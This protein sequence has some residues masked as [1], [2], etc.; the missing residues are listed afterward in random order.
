[1]TATNPARTASQF[2]RDAKG[3]TVSLRYDAVNGKHVIYSDDVDG[4]CGISYVTFDAV[5]QARKAWREARRE[6][7]AAGFVPCDPI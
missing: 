3:W 1:M 2:F 7:I 4:D 6:L 5:E